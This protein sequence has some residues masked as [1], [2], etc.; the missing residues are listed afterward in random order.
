MA[1]SPPRLP[2]FESRRTLLRGFK[3]VKPRCVGFGA[4]GS[5]YMTPRHISRT[6]AVPSRPGVPGTAG[7]FLPPRS[8]RAI[9]IHASKSYGFRRVVQDEYKSERG[10]DW[11]KCVCGE[12]GVKIANWRYGNRIA[13]DTWTG[14]SA[15]EGRRDPP[16]K[17]LEKGYRP[18]I[19]SIERT[20]DCFSTRFD[21]KR[22]SMGVDERDQAPTWRC[23]A[24]AR[25]FEV[26]A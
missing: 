6:A 2:A 13:G 4:E 26:P 16:E 23:S 14:Q 9:H 11:H 8:S 17:I 25:H 21:R 19:G 10:N 1:S 22:A 7:S 3:G 20:K 15:H 24:R 12:N 18:A 5:P